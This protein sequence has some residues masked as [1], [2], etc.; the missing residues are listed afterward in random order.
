MTV[1]EGKALAAELGVPF[2]EACALTGANVEEVRSTDLVLHHASPQQSDGHPQAFMLLTTA[3]VARLSEDGTLAAA[4][5]P[6]R[7]AAPSAPSDMPAKCTAGPLAVA[8][9]AAALV[10]AGAASAP[11][12]ELVEHDLEEAAAAAAEPAAASLTPR[13][14]VDDKDE[15]D[16]S[17]PPSM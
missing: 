6:A 16:V 4:A 17:D 8:A 9:A 15:A 3:V 7:T 2:L 11:A 10:P 13:A 1:E 12:F 14:A 5:A